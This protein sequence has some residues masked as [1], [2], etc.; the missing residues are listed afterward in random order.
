M[1]ICLVCWFGW[2][3]TTTFGPVLDPSA[4]INAKDDSEDVNLRVNVWYAMNAP[5]I[6]KRSAPAP[7]SLAVGSFFPSFPFISSN[8]PQIV[9]ITAEP[10]AKLYDE[11][12]I[13]TGSRDIRTDK[14]RINDRGVWW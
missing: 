7:N 10:A 12:N 9:P 5:K 4:L 13:V 1:I 6:V 14:G 2:L 8:P 3:P 11:S